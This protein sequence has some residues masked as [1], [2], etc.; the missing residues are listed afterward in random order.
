MSGIHREGPVVEG[1]TDR[2]LESCDTYPQ[3]AELSCG[4]ELEP[5]PQPFP[6]EAS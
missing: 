4:L 3:K 1:D 6:E 5:L 2:L